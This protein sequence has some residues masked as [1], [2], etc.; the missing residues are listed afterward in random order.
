[1]NLMLRVLT[2]IKRKEVMAWILKDSS[3]V[4]MFL[5]YENT[6]AGPWPRRDVPFEKLPRAIYLTLTTRWHL[7]NR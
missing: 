3:F 5:R 2:K 1:M 4:F 7:Q 6:P